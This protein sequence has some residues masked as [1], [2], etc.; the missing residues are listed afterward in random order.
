MKKYLIL[1]LLFIQNVS[2]CQDFYINQKY[3]VEYLNYSI[4]PQ[5]ENL[6]LN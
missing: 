1:V 5:W 6:N 2:Y 4:S 3:E